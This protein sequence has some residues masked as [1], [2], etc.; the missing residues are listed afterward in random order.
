MCHKCKY[1]G[2]EFETSVKLG[3]HVSKCPLNPNKNQQKIHKIIKENFEKRNP[4]EEHKLK[5]V[6]CGKEAKHLVVWG[7][8]Y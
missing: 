6:V 3:G 1:C 4:L 5:C 7:I 2:K 8:Q